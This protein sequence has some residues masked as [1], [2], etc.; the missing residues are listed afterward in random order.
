[1]V[2]PRPKVRELSESIAAP[3]TAKRK[4]SVGHAN[5]VSSSIR[6]DYSDRLNPKISGE[7][8]PISSATITE[9]EGPSTAPQFSLPFDQQYQVDYSP[10]P[11][12]V[13]QSLP[14][15][16]PRLAPSNK[17]P[18]AFPEWQIRALSPPAWPGSLRS[19]ESQPDI[20][21][22]GNFIFDSKNGSGVL[23]FDPA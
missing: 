19:I 17:P 10:A 11:S 9:S 4:L 12:G 22:P 21:S 15:V 7:K 13:P 2:S 5:A 20:V 8:A 14:W 16:F 6:D 18:V 3:T 1:M 23:P